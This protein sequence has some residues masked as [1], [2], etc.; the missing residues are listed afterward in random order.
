MKRRTLPTIL[1]SGV[2]PVRAITQPELRDE[3]GDRIFTSI[4]LPYQSLCQQIERLER[5]ESSALVLR[6]DFP[7]RTAAASPAGAS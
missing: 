5:A 6:P 2:C 7:S 3:L 4:D 1:G